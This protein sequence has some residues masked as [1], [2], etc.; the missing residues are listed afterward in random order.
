MQK[1][2]DY[3][4]LRNEIFDYFGY[5]E[6]WVVYPIDDSRKYYWKLSNMDIVEFTDLITDFDNPSYYNQILDSGVFRGKDYTMVAV[7]T[8]T[9]GNKFLQIF[10][11]SKEIK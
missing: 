3:F 9:D 8:Q 10:D 2:D 5:T 4:M 7:D 1:L 6:N 11:N